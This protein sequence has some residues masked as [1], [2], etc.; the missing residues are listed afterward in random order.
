MKIQIVKP[1][2]KAFGEFDG[3]KIK[4]QKPIGFSKER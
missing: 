3:G 2:Q 4:E 1:Q